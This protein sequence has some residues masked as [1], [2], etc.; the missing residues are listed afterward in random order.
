MYSSYPKTAEIEKQGRDDPAL[1]A[2]QP[3]QQ[4]SPDANWSNNQLITLLA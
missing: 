1:Q 3:T 4:V 2:I